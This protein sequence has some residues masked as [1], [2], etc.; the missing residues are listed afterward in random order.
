M[1]TLT[2]ADGGWQATLPPV[3][4]GLYTLRADVL[5]QDG[6][7]ISRAET[8][9]LREAP[10]QL[11]ALLPQLPAPQSPASAPQPAPATPPLAAQIVTV[12]PGFTLW[13]IA[14]QAFGD[15]IA[16]V[17][18]LEANKDQIRNPDLI[19]PGQVFKLPSP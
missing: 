14:Q 1:E 13:G 17:K 4:P 10:A 6:K 18:V 5:A 16:Y 7:V 11:A 19:Y 3:A 12:Q 15:G 2:D 9:F 8:P